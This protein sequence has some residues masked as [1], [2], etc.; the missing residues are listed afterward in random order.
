MKNSRFYAVAFATIT[1]CATLCSAAPPEADPYEQYVKTSKDFHPVRQDKAW[2]LTA[3]PSWTYMPW[4]FKWTIGYNDASGKWSVDHGYNGAF[5]DWG[6]ISAD[7][8]KTGRIDWINNFKL[9]FYMDHLAGKHYLHQWD[10]AE[11][12]RH[13]NELHSNGMRPKPLNA[14]MAQTLHGFIRSN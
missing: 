6:N 4:T 8:S 3:Y 13:Y 10:S 12:K 11:M 7:G 9:H 14:A 5:I 2:L 1:L